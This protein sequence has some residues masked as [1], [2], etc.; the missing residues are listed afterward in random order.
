MDAVEYQRLVGSR[1]RRKRQMLGWSQGELARRVVMPQS[2]LSRLERGAFSLVHLWQLRQLI[3]VLLTSPDF[4]L[5]AS[6]DP[7][8]VPL[9]GCPAEGLDPQSPSPLPATIIPEDDDCGEYTSFPYR[10]PD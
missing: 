7:G 1:I 3:D 6:D 9:P 5:G 4:I 2:Q 8:E 10:A